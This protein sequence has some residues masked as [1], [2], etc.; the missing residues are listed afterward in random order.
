MTALR[1]LKLIAAALVLI[2]LVG[3]VGF[4]FIE[5]WPWF[6]GF[7]MTITT[8]T[9][10]GY[11]ETHPLSHAGRVFNS[12]LMLVGVGTVFLAIGSLTQALLEFELQS[13][14][15]RKRM[16]REISRLTGHYIIC[17]AGRVGRSVAREFGRK[18]APFVIVENKREKIDRYASEGWLSLEGDATQE[19]TLEEAGIARAKGL[20]AAT[21][22]DATNIYIVLTARA[23]NPNLKIIARAS[24]DSAEKHLRTAG[25]DNV[26]SPY[27][28]AGSRIA[29]TLMRPGV[30][31]FF[32]AAHGH[33]GMDLEMDEIPVTSG[34]RLAGKTIATS[35]IRQETGVIV[36]AIHRK[37]G[38]RFNPTSDD[39]IQA[40]D[41]L[42][43]MGDPEKLRILEQAAAA[44]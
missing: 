13:V 38:M 20:V 15:G 9:T 44:K 32:D 40:G 18:P 36:L 1:N 31:N 17:G 3:M 27:L 43:A 11:M 41:S 7:Y 24:E 22:A 37:D 19:R 16:E 8:L 28:F 42:I 4:H 2:V 33:L 5:G 23:M 25:A 35:G 30:M 21:T 6:D 10:I 26:I 14:F 34:S 39:V 29:Q 12:V